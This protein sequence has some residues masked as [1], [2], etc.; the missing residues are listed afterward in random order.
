MV[1]AYIEDKNDKPGNPR[2]VNT[3][4]HVSNERPGGSGREVLP[5][6][7]I[8]ATGAV[9]ADHNPVY[10]DHSITNIH[11]L[12]DSI[13][14]R[15]IS[16]VH[17]PAFN[18]TNASTAT[19]NLKL[20]F[21]FSTGFSTRQEKLFQ[22]NSGPAEGKSPTANAPYA[23]SSF[24]N[25]GRGVLILQPSPVKAGLAFTAGVI[26]MKPVSK[27]FDVSAGL[28]YSYSSDHIEIGSPVNSYIAQIDVQAAAFNAATNGSTTK[29]MDYT[30]RYHYIELPVSV[31]FNITPKWKI[32]LVWN[33]G[34]LV[35]RLVSTNVLIYDGVLGGVYYEG[36]KDVNKTQL[37]LSTGFA[38][39]FGS[40]NHMQWSIGPEF[41]LNTSKLFQNN[42][43]KNTYP[44][45]GGLNVQVLFPAG[46]KKRS[47]F[48]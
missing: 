3:V 47:H 27:R 30:N 29:K 1:N 48:F 26:A 11:L 20:G 7:E 14:D 45:Y 10:I 8:F 21:V 5:A 23:L 41:N 33:A 6:G 43:D 15:T 16:D 28:Q 44:V 46:K 32:P 19:G 17:L 31:Y 2:Q 36:R 34:F 22:L 40:T 39:R 25:A 24:A 13:T 12:P 9:Y 42:Y 38:F 18:K 4:V 35:S 37:A